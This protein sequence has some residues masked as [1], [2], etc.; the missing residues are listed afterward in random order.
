MIVVDINWIRKSCALCGESFEE[1]RTISAG[2]IS[3]PMFVSG[4]LSISH[5]SFS[6]HRVI[7]MI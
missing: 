2:S 7:I 1:A 3:I 5:N 4:S 6:T